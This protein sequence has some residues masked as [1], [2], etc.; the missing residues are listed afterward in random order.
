MNS[1]IKYPS[2]TFADGKCHVIPGFG[3]TGL[4]ETSEG[5]VIFDVPIR[6]LAR[7]TFTEIRNKTDK[8]VK[9]LIF[10]H[11]HFDHAFGHGPIFKEIEEKG[12]KMPE[13]IGHENIVRRFK[14]YK[15][16]DQYHDWIN[17][18]QFASIAPKGNKVSTVS[19]EHALDPTI[20]LIGNDAK[21][22]FDLGGIEFNLYHD[23][24]ET[25]DSIWL[26]VP[27]KETIC[28]GDL[29]LSSFPNVG[30]PYKVQRYPL[31]WAL[32]LD[33][34]IGR[35]NNNFRSNALCS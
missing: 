23:K 10:S 4:F 35:F 16:L 1:I 33:K 26:W 25:D 18:Q 17:S 24:G 22:S 11:G 32:A 9:Y 27:E 3:N 12:W 15:M 6:Q 19:P 8:Q 34:M 2:A 14:K 7:K 20:L 29:L 5:L 21:Y 30:N 13:I 28:T 31:D